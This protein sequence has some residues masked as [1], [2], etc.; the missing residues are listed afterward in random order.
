MVITSQLPIVR[1]HEAVGDPALVDA[2]SAQRG[3]DQFKQQLHA[4]GKRKIDSQ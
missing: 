3:K 2:C 1:W 4:Q